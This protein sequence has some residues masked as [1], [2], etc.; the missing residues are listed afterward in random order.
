VETG[1]YRVVLDVGG[2]KLTT[3]LRVV[4][5]VPGNGSVMSPFSW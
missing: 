1:N 5:V 4:E 2:Q 3:V